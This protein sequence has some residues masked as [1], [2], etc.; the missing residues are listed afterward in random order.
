MS[1]P[2]EEIQPIVEIDENYTQHELYK[3]GFVDG[4]TA[5]DQ[6]NLNLLLS[7]IKINNQNIGSLFTNQDHD[8]KNIT[9]LH[10]SIMNLNNGI[11][12]KGG[13]VADLIAKHPELE[14]V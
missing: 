10:E 9:S 12:V 6:K 13:T 14:E 8:H 5:L 4:Q 1:L 2:Y 11:L 7:L 3:N